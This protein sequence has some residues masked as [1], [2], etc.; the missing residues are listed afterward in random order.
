[1]IYVIA[2]NQEDA[3]HWCYG[4][5]LAR[6]RVLFCG[7]HRTLEGRRMFDG[8]RIVVTDKATRHPNYQ[9]IVDVLRR[10]TAISALTDESR[11][12]LLAALG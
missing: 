3:R 8:D 4:H 5:G 11:A 7:T 9:E 12:N 2:E 6:Y 10:N 1:M